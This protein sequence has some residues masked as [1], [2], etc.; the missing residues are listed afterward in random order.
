MPPRLPSSSGRAIGA[1]S[2]LIEESQTVPLVYVKVL[3]LLIQAIHHP[4]EVRASG[5]R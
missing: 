3:P 1:T 2:M 4:R 5:Q